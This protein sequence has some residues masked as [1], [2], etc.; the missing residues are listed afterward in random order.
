M[1]LLN[2]PSG[3]YPD[4]VPDT[5]F[6]SVD[7]AAGR[8]K[9]LFVVE[10]E[11]L[12]LSAGYL[13]AVED[14]ELKKRLTVH[15]WQDARR[16]DFIRKRTLELRFPRKDV[17]ARTASQRAVM[18]AAQELLGCRGDAEFATGVY[19]VW[20]RACLQGYET[21]LSL[22]DPL[23][24][25]PTAEPLTRFVSDLS[26]Q[27]AEIEGLLHRLYRDKP[28][29]NPLAAGWER[30]CVAAL[31]E[32]SAQA[33]EDFGSRL[34]RPGQGAQEDTVENRKPYSPPA[35]PVRD[36]RFTP[37]FHHNA[38]RRI[39][40]DDRFDE[41]LEKKLI[42]GISHA[43]EMWAAEAVGAVMWAWEDMPWDFYTDAARWLYDEGRHCRMGEQMM[44]RLGFETGID[45]PMA[46]ESYAALFPHGYE[47]LLGLLHYFE[48]TNTK[49]ASK[50]WFETAG[51]EDSASNLDYDW[52]DEALHL[53][54][55]YKW[56]LHRLG[57]DSERLEALR[58]ESARIWSEWFNERV[59][60]SPD[61][62]YEVFRDRILR[63]AEAKGL[64]PAGGS[65]A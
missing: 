65:M 45:Y 48:S 9:L 52:A 62:P 61:K 38:D 2:R 15:V 37:T 35:V 57:G 1:A 8:L 17:D 63:L 54:Y 43:N 39:L 34:T 40:P 19:L 46:G 23:L 13:P 55:G 4:D 49:Q 27:I 47:Q 42:Q 18:K 44:S 29:M 41:A 12:R 7:E 20:K 51:D 31:L 22:T 58:D 11:L 25:E 50:E 64:L 26:G 3:A 28:D 56:L 36:S 33:S 10:K 16:A 14:W 6:Q 32:V 60:A 5:L 59:L 30:H 53:T 21:Y 24:D